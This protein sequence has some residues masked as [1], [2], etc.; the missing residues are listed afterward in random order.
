[1]IKVNARGQELA[2]DEATVWNKWYSRLLQKLPTTVGEIIH[3]GQ[4]LHSIQGR[5]FLA[6]CTQL[7]RSEFGESAS[8]HRVCQSWGCAIFVRERYLETNNRE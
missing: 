7:A 3:V 8:V 4:W 5:E 6:D 2:A 1:L